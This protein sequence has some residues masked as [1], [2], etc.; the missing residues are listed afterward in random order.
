MGLS[1]EDYK[2]YLNSFIKSSPIVDYDKLLKGDD[3]AI[4]TL[5]TLA[6]TFKNSHKLI[7]PVT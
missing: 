3:K 4:I 7:L 2:L 5:S 6:L 1:I